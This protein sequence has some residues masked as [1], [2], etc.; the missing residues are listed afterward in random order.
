MTN[1]SFLLRQL[2]ALDIGSFDVL[3]IHASL[4]KVGPVVGGADSLL[5]ALLEAL[6]QNGTL[7]MLLAADDREPFAPATSPAD[8]DVG[9]LAEVFR[10]RPGT[11]VNDHV[12]ARFAAYGS[13]ATE[14]LEPTPLHDYYGPG[15]VLERFTAMNSAVLRLAANIDTVTL[16]HWAEYK[17]NLSHKRRVRRRYVRADIGEQWVESL[18]D[19]DGIVVWTQGDYFSQLLIDFLATGHA[20]VEPVGK[21]T[22]ELFE[23][24]TFVSF[25]VTWLETH[26]AS[27][28]F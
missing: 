11:K 16:T 20:R 19:T 7:I 17:A 14:L 22:A 28:N 23:A 12:T 18:D 13:K 10:Q 5:D 21:C 26:L 2:K 4:R 25:A 8:P 24:N 27:R 3:M 15:S 6:G 9:V 1:Y